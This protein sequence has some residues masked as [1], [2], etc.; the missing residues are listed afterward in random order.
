[1]YR[2]NYSL[3]AQPILLFSTIQFLKNWY[4]RKEKIM[5]FTLIIQHGL[6]AAV[7]NVSTA[8]GV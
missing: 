5:D 2:N 7:P 6:V 8:L 3:D 1:M 4:E